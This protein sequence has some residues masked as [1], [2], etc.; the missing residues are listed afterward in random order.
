MTG[1]F[2][3]FL[4][5]RVSFFGVKVKLLLVSGTLGFSLTSGFGF[6]DWIYVEAPQAPTHAFPTI[7]G[8]VS[9]V[10]LEEV[11]LT[12]SLEFDDVKFTVTLEFEDVE[13]LESDSL[14][15]SFEAVPFDVEFEAESVELLSDVE[16]EAD[17]VAFPL[18]VALSA[19]CS[20]SFAASSSFAYVP[21]ANTVNSKS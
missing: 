17:S 4:T 19:A 8:S 11:E 5:L 7:S 9:L 18:D 3:F 15:V 13:F 10:E 6:I 20:A 12:V 2:G 14:L 16:F 1:K 21:A